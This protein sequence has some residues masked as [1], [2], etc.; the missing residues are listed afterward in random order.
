MTKQRELV[1]LSYTPQSSW[2]GM[3]GPCF[4][5][6]CLIV[7]GIQDLEWDTET[8]DGNMVG[9]PSSLEISK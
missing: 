7:Q 4:E 1:K 9:E 6:T 5:R 2:E 8:W 3:V